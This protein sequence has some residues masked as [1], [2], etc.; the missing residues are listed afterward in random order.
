[1]EH[2]LSDHE[3]EL[4][5]SLA[6]THSKKAQLYLDISRTFPDE[7]PHDLQNTLTLLQEKKLVHYNPVAEGGHLFARIT[8]KGM[9]A[10]YASGGVSFMK[11]HME[12][13]R[14]WAGITAVVLLIIVML[15]GILPLHSLLG[16]LAGTG[17]TQKTT[18]ALEDW[19]KN[20]EQED[21]EF[22]TYTLF[23]ESGDLKSYLVECREDRELECKYKILFIE[24]DEAKEMVSNVEYPRD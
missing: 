6:H 5:T 19:M 15:S 4:L 9:E 13:F 1:M 12:N 16:D 10:L 2:N 7:H 22:Y 14:R 3:K 8:S 11:F 18:V 23:E 24:V 17:L 20:Q 21:P